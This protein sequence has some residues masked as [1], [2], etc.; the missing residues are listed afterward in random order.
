M[1]EWTEEDPAWG[2]ALEILRI[3]RGWT[4]GQLGDAVGIGHSTVSNYEAGVRTAEV[5]LLRQMVAAMGFPAHLLDRACAH[6]RW[7]R[8]ARQLYR[9]PPTDAAAACVEASAG[10]AG[11]AREELARATLSGVLGLPTGEGGAPG[12]PPASPGRGWAPPDEAP[13]EAAP[14]PA[15]WPAIADHRRGRG[16]ARKGRSSSA[17]PQALRVLRLIAGLGREELGA[18]IGVSTGVIQSYERGKTAPLAMTLQRL[19]D[20]MDLP[21]EVFDRT[22]RFLA[23]ARAARWWWQREGAASPRARIEDLAAWEARQAEE[24]TRAWLGRLQAAARLIDGRRRAPELWARLARHPPAARRALVRES[25]EFQ[26]AAL[27]ELLCEESV[28][29]AGDSA[30]RALRLAQLAVLA[31]ERVADREGWRQRVEGYARA[32]LTNALRVGGKLAAAGAAFARAAELWQAGATEDPGLLNEARVLGLEASLRR[33]RREVPQALA[34]LERALAADRWGETPALLLSKAK[35]LEELGDFAGSIAVLRQAA[36]QIDGER[37]PRKLFAAQHN[38]AFNLCHLGRHA[39]A[40]L[41]LPA[42]R[43]LALRL[44]NRL[45]GLRVGWLEA[46]VAAGLGRSAEAVEGFARVRAAFEREGIAYDAA[47][48]TL[49]LAGVHASLGRTADV[50]ALARASAPIFR[51]QGVHREARRALDLFRR[52]AEEERVSAELVRGLLAYLQ[53]ARHDRSLRYREAA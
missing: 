22:V 4:Q 11:V 46:K 1:R 38:V 3:V 8:A 34:L 31:G 47:L 13:G 28:K 15:A 53:R 33:D 42:V 29:A 44:G 51:R 50:K 43:A 5:A 21:P 17:L 37:E 2:A 10:A 39:D 25:A 30:R 19:L 32:H 41:A 7:A 24:G 6:V 36:A 40:A 12:S 48:A 49:E 45:D 27:C 16:G 18:A 52:A 35:A 14:E 23:A 9:Q 26:D 20:A